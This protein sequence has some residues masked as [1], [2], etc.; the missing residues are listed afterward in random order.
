MKKTVF[1]GELKHADIKPTNSQEV[2]RKII[3]L[4]VL[5]QIYLTFLNVVCMINLNIDFFKILSEYQCG[6]RKEFSKQH[7]LLARIEKLRKSLDSVEVG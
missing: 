1:P 4:Y 3:H 2:K 6:F 7:C 5:Y